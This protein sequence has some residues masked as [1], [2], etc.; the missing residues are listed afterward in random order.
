MQGFSIFRNPSAGVTPS[1]PE[2]A[3]TIA[4]ARQSATFFT[5]V[6]PVSSWG[7]IKLPLRGHPPFPFTKNPLKF[8][9]GKTRPIPTFGLQTSSSTVIL[10]FGGAGQKGGSAI[11]NFPLKPAGFK[12][13]TPGR[14]HYKGTG[15][16]AFNS[17]SCVATPQGGRG[18]RNPSPPC[19]GHQRILWRIVFNFLRESSRR[20]PASTSSC[21]PKNR[22]RGK[23][24]G[25]LPFW[26]DFIYS[27]FPPDIRADFKAL[28][29]DARAPGVPG[30]G[31]GTPLGGNFSGGPLTDTFYSRVSLAN[32]PRGILGSSNPDIRY[33]I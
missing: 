23:F 30:S 20:G 11:L 3:P 16:S 10:A 26:A 15:F 28:T 4:R 29:C 17:N 12:N 22:S 32:S 5:A 31:G 1:V 19:R 33:A 13:T 21:K 24:L 14:R 8:G 18:V 6:E 2:C 7:P 25:R 27:P 9:V